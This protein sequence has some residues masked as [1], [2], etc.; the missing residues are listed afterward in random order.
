[1]E[2]QSNTYTKIHGELNEAS[3]V[4]LLAPSMGNDA[5]ELCLNL[6]AEADVSNTNAMM[7][8]YTKTPDSCA[9]EWADY[10]G[11]RPANMKILSVGDTTRSAATQSVS[12]TAHTA[13]PG[14]VETIANP[15]DLT[16][17]GI[18]VSEQ[19]ELW[20]DTGNRSA[21]CFHSLTPLLQYVDLQTAFKFLHVFTGRIANIDGVAHFHI[22]PDAHDTQTINTLKSLFDA[23]V[24]DKGDGDWSVT[25]K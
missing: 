9:Q 4:L 22:D 6:F 8:T 18:K 17:L 1:M 3:N 2:T 15:G 23:I 20:K 10:V 24:E 19:L 5:D 12:N 13:K 16:G 14:L 11:K 7:V 21:I 25:T